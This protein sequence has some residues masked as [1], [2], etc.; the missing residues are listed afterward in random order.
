MTYILQSKYLPLAVWI[1][2]LNLLV[3]AYKRATVAAGIRHHPIVERTLPLVPVVLGAAS[4]ALFPD[5]IGLATIVSG[6]AVPWSAGLMYGAGAGL[7][8]GHVFSLIREAAPERYAK[9]LTMDG[10]EG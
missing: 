5:L 2:L 10:V 6:E 8:S 4:G 1:L 9:H 3:Q 7:A